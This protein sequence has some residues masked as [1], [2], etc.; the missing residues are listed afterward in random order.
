MLDINYNVPTSFVK[1]NSVQCS[2]T[3][4]FID[5]LKRNVDRQM[6]IFDTCRDDWESDRDELE[7]T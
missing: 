2:C 4:I 3:R 5:I 1:D 6:I 7:N